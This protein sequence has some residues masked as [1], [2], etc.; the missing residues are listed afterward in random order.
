MKSYRY[1][2]RLSTAFLSRFKGLMFVG[3]II[4]FFV[5]LFLR[6]FFP[7]MAGVP[8]EYIGMTGRF[9]SDGMP[10]E[11]LAMVSDGLT[12]L[13]EEGDAVGN[14]AETWE[15]TD[16]GRTWVFQIRSGVKW[17][18]G[19]EVTSNTIQYFF[20]DVEISRPDA[21]TIVFKLDS[22]F[23]PFPIVVSR[24]T[25][26]QGL[27]GTGV[28]RVKKISLAG[29]YVK[30]LE[31]TNGREKKVIK[32]YPTEE[33]TKTAFKLGE[34][35]KIQDVIN[36]TPF[37]EWNT[38]DISEEVNLGRY[39]GIFFNTEEGRSLSDKKL[40]QALSYSIDKNS[41]SSERAIG[42]I[43]PS[44]WAY[45][46]QIKSYDYDI[47]HAK[48][49]LSDFSDEALENLNINLS[50]TPTLL[51]IAESVASYWRE[52]GVKTEV[53]V[54]P[55]LPTDYQAFLAIY[56]IP[57]DPDQYST[58]HS[59]Q[60][61]TNISHLSNP[62]IDKLLEDGRLE[63]GPDERKKIYLDFQRF[64]LE[65]APAVFLYHPVNYTVNRK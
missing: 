10:N 43:S 20:E 65:D 57:E 34:I 58:W 39:V 5:F 42:P 13:D 62:R 49:L 44:S 26:K 22:P 59:T 37:N 63:L 45:N 27:L 14:L 1:Y 3:V 23:A 15:T 51:P 18:D 12:S 60:L 32:F 28:W 31:L 36:P 11:I 17:H 7:I 4:G 52:I 35:D 24:P 21:R 48:E 41:F 38:V 40:R 9:H 29:A 54:T 64:L 16:D 56:D 25:F 53:H 47:E 55:V 6:F 2:L 33:K 30:K 46:P 8:V 61:V 19:S 50:T